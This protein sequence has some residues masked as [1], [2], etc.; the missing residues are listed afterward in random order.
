M[1]PYPAYLNNPVNPASEVEFLNFQN[2]KE[3]PM[4]ELSRFLGIIVMYFND[5]APPHFH[6]EYNEYKAAI[7]IET[8]GVLEGKLPGKV[9]SLVVEWAAE[10]KD[11]LL[12]NWHS[13]RATGKF[14][15]ISPLV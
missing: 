3:Y 13:I 4:P 10:H 7:A 1:L 2:R 6:A 14:H 9:L 8:L 11:E 15:K 5:H 12:E